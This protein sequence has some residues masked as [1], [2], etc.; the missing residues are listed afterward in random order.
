MIAGYSTSK[1][2]LEDRI[3]RLMFIASTVGF[4]EITY[5]RPMDNNCWAVFTSTG[6]MLVT[7][8]NDSYIITMYFANI[9]KVYA[10]WNGKV[11]K[12]LKEIILKN[13]KKG[14]VK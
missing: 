7:D 6:I 2:L 9:E 4:G 10:L 14:Y 8:K 3:D 13:K 12:D 11:P 1:H 5:K